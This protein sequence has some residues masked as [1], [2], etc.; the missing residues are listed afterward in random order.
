MLHPRDK[1]ATDIL[2]P[3]N[4]D[5]AIRMK[6]R[7]GEPGSLVLLLRSFW[8]AA[9]SSVSLPPPAHGMRR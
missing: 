7:A 9:L 4:S 8:V 1:R 2:L 3:N 5:E 6:M